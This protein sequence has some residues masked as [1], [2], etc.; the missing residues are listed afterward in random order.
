MSTN[1]TSRAVEIGL[2][3]HSTEAERAVLG[4]LMVLYGGT[5]IA[6]VEALLRPDDFFNLRHAWIYEALVRVHGKHE[7]ADMRLVAEELRQAGRLEDIGGEYYL[8]GLA[9]PHAYNAVHYAG[10]VSDYADRRRLIAAA[11]DV[12]RLAYDTGRELVSVKGQALDAVMEAASR[13]TSVHFQSA[14]M[15]TDILH[16]NLAEGIQPG[17]KTGFRD[18]DRHFRNGMTRGQYWLLAAR[19]AM[20]KSALALRIAR[21]AASGKTTPDNKPA[22]VLYFTF[23]MTAEDNQIR[24]ISELM[25]TPINDVY[26]LKPEH[27]R[28]SLFESSCDALANM[29]LWYEE[30]SDS[31]EAMQ[32]AIQQFIGKYGGVDLIVLD[33]VELVVVEGAQAGEENRLLTRV[34]STLLRT[35][36][37]LAPVL[38]IAQL[39]RAVESRANKRPLLSDLRM[40]GSLEQDAT[41]VMMLYRDHYYSPEANEHDAEILIR[42]NRQGSVGTV[43]LYFRPELTSFT[44]I[45]W[46]REER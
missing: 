12:A 18:I 14:S 19:P 13:R 36:R 7:A 44:D 42:K 30:E 24:L 25:S 28:W 1:G 35:A 29:R 4:A 32:A 26:D 16:D 22:R 21:N 27:E 33:R 46:H 8:N 41:V 39:N 11:S 34:S 43:K 2:A 40:S 17:I 38:A 20:G 6:Q 10:I 5:E 45:D 9:S 31:L 37:R 23:E 15:T 3:P